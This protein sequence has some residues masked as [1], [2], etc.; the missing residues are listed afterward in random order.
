MV[1][2]S[3]RQA[4]L[5]SSNKAESAA[6]KDQKTRTKL[7]KKTLVMQNPLFLAILVEEEKK[8]SVE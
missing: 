3:N 7:Q 8:E 5:G 6:G 1:S 4:A 2:A